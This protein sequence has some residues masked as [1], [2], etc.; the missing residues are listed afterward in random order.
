MVFW[1]F[2]SRAQE[3]NAFLILRVGG[4]GTR[5]QAVSAGVPGFLF[6]SK[7][8]R[9]KVIGNCQGET[10]S[11][12][13]HGREASAKQQGV[14]L[15]FSGNRLGGGGRETLPVRGRLDTRPLATAGDAETQDAFHL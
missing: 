4:I 8:I 3:R 11:G 15:S 10:G 13:G 5:F 9:R 12:L 14:Q 7:R 2:T 6:S 1:S